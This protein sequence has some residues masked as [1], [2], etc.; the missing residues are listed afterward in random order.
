M[1]DIGLTHQNSRVLKFKDGVLIETNDEIE[2]IN[3]REYVI[4]SD[5]YE[6]QDL[7]ED[8]DNLGLMKNTGV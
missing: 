6:L 3:Y 7:E 8:I 1:Y 4:E 5:V 2:E